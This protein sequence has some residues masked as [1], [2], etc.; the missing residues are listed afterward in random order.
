MKNIY[1]LLLHPEWTLSKR[2]NLKETTTVKTTKLEGDH[3]NLA[4]SMFYKNKLS[5]S[6]EHVEKTVFPYT[7]Y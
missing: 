6:V 7:R 1:G 4:D 3:E 2:Q 5:D